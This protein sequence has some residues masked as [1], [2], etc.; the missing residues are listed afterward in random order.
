MSDP[1]GKG[2]LDK[3]G[4]FMAVKLIT[5]AQTGKDVTMPNAIQDLDDLPE[6]SGDKPVIRPPSVP[7]MAQ[8]LSSN[9]DIADEM[10]IAYKQMFLTV[11]EP[12]PPGQPSQVPGNKV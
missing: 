7:P 2:F 8:P 4:L 9:F 1:Q 3:S 6:M 5:L 12:G 11:A 10:F